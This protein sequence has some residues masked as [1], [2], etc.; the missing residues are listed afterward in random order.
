MAESYRDKLRRR[1]Q[2]AVNDKGKTG[3]GRKSALDF[4]KTTKAINYFQPKTGRGEENAI[5]I[6]PFII[7]QEWYQKLR[8][9]SGRPVGLEPGDVDYVLML[10]LHSGVGPNNDVFLCLREAFGQECPI[11]D[12]MFEFY[13]QGEKEKAAAV[14][15]RWRCWYIFRIIIII[16][17]IIP[18]PP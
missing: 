15:P 16:I 2:Q 7:T 3:L 5:D 12:D 8:T 10:P 17:N 18:T 11:C 14:R 9:P 1:Q 13:R 4:S 6:L